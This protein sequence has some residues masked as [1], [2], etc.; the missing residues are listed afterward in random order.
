MSV[1]ARF[2]WVVAAIVAAYFLAALTYGLAVWLAYSFRLWDGSLSGPIQTVLIVL[3]LAV[4]I[5]CAVQSED[6]GIRGLWVC[7]AIALVEYSGLKVTGIADPDFPQDWLAQHVL[8]PLRHMA[9][10]G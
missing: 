10:L 7:A 5:F 8:A 1:V 9:G 2:G 4:M 3:A 6:K